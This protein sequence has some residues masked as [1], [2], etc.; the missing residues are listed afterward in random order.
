MLTLEFL[1]PF[2]GGTM[3]IRHPSPNPESGESFSLYRARITN[4]EV[5]GNGFLFDNKDILPN[6]FF[7]FNWT[8]EPTGGL[9]IAWAPPRCFKVILNGIIYFQIDDEI[10]I[11]IHANGNFLPGST[12]YRYFPLKNPRALLNF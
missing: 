9:L 8:R 3:F 1:K 12:P 6:K 2:I 11:T 10:D 7:K 5:M 4:I